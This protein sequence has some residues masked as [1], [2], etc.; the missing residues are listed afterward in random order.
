MLLEAYINW[1]LARPKSILAGCIAISA[2]LVAGVPGLGLT[3][4]MR[5]YFSDDNPQLAAFNAL[6]DIYDKQDN[7]YFFVVPEKGDV[8]NRQVL[9]LIWELTELGWQV[10]YSRRANSLANYQ[11]TYASED[12]LVVESLIPDPGGLSKARI[13][14]LK[15][16]CLGEETLRGRLVADDGSAA[17]IMV[18]L[19]LPDH[20]LQAN[21]E[22][23]EWVDRALA[24][25]R[26]RYPKITIHVGGTTAT[27]VALG[28]AVGRDMRTLVALSYVTIFAGLFVLLRHLGA[29]LATIAVVTLSVAATMGVFGWLGATLSAV[30]G[31]VPTV[32]MTIAVADSVHILITY[33]YALRRDATNTE[34]IREALRVNAA[35]VFITS[36]TTAIGVL[37]LNFSDSPPYRDLGNMVAVGVLLAYLLSMT[38]LPAFLCCIRLRQ[39]DHG[40]RQERF[41]NAFADWVIHH[42]RRLLWTFGP[43]ILLVALLIPR[44]VLTERWHE[45]FDDSFAVRQAVDA[46]AEKMGFLHKIRYSV[47]AQAVHGI[48]QPAFLHAVEG[49][50]RWYES[51]SGVVYVERL[52]DIIKRLNQNLHADDPAYR[53]LPDSREA[54]AQYLLLYE[55]SLPLGLG[56]EN[57]VSVDRS[58][59]QLTV[60]V[61]RTD[62]ERLL[63]LDRRARAWIAEHAP[64]LSVAEG[65]GVDMMFAHINH[66]NIRS[67]LIG[68]VFALVLISGLLVVAL[69]SVKLGLLSLITNLAPA[70]LAYGM[71]GLFVGRIDLSASVVMCMS[72][73]IVVDDTVHFLSKYLRARREQRL[74]AV[75]GMR[76]AF[77]TVGVALCITTTVLVAGFL[78]LG[79]SHFAPS[80]TT[81][82]LL[83]ITLSFALLVDFLLMPPL[84]LAL[85]KRWHVGF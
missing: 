51:Q 27:N 66:R 74:D 3:N 2:L 7:V 65:S 81:G 37:S 13:A 40:E 49:F 75:Q 67:L 31:F 38:F 15:T 64:Q 11:H 20:D 58:A 24:K 6:E 35:P 25:L 45:Y 17:G 63:E 5:A 33:F 54:A 22:V 10:P 26:A 47:D 61:E 71:W 56:L 76:Y 8:F 69:R 68:M 36:I 30:A 46:V 55:L 12:A 9:T 34:A 43:L 82:L 29:T 72:I 85:D 32:V 19:S 53:V 77:N 14:A 44:N 23:I 70:A 41:M 39:P 78:I 52:S 18:D 57:L 59:T 28:D 42:Y 79:A 1:V 4:D 80:V 16:I 48:H 50:A 60:F 83:A 62:S 84:L 21:D 73:G